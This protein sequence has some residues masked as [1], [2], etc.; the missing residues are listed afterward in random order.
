MDP[1]LRLCSH[2]RAELLLFSGCGGGGL[3]SLTAPPEEDCTVKRRRWRRD[4][5]LITVTH[6]KQPA[7]VPIVIHR[8]LEL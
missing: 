6:P 1:Y 7:S 5:M 3:S 4:A 8:T 2:C